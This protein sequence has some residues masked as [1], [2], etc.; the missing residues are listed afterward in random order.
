MLLKL[1]KMNVIC[2]IGAMDSAGNISTDKPR[3]L[4]W[5]E[6]G[7]IQEF[8]WTNKPGPIQGKKVL[9]VL[10]DDTGEIKLD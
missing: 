1:I 2:V 5:L 8:Y 7:T 10:D 4:S 3:I 9:F 6:H